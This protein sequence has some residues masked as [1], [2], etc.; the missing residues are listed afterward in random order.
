MP[1]IWLRARSRAPLALKRFVNR[2][3]DCYMSFEAK[4]RRNPLTR[5]N[6]MDVNSGERRGLRGLGPGRTQRRETSAVA[7]MAVE[8]VTARQRFSRMTIV[9]TYTATMTAGITT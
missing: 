4:D 2:M 8:R 6:G 3:V 5:S 7:G 9:T 1:R